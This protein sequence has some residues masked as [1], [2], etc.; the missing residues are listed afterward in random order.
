MLIPGHWITCD[1]GVIRPVIQSEIQAADGSWVQAELL[2]DTGA[3][4]TA[5]TAELLESLGLPHVVAL[6]Q[7]GGLGGAA[8]TVTVS[9]EVRLPLEKGSP[10]TF[11]GKF[12]AFTD[13]AA[14]EINI[15]GRD[16]MKLFAVIVDQPGGSIA[17]ISKPHRY[18]IE[19]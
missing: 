16:I 19:I 7:L 5:F 13:P 17:L 11:Q 4:R 10:I 14:L 2:I 9:T 15:L 8:H 6:Q 18:R 1:D 3:D 12:A